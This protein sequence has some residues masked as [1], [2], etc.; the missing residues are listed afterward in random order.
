VILECS[1]RKLEYLHRGTKTLAFRLPK[2]GKIRKFLGKTGPLVAPSANPEGKKP[3]RNVREAQGYFGSA[4]D[5]YLDGGLV[6][7]EPST[8]IEIRR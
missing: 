5:F 7:A 3:A 6:K 8:L 4:V 2:D 1:N